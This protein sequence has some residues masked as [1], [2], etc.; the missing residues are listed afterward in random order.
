MAFRNLSRK[1]RVLYIVLGSI[2]FLLI[3]FRL[4]LPSI[5]LKYVNR[6]LAR[7]DGYTGHVK[8]IDVSLY[9]GAYTIKSIY[10]NKTGGKVPVPFFKADVIDLSVEWR[11][12]FHGR[13]VAEIEVRKPVLNFVKGPTKETS[14]TDIDNDWTV[15]VDKLIP[16]K[17][18][19]F[20]IRDG[21]IHYRD[22]YSSPKVDI[23]ATSVEIIAENLSNA[24]H[25]KDSLPSTV[26]ATASVYDG[27]A[28]MD[29][30]IDPLN[31]NLTFDL[32]AKLTTL[33]LTRLNDFLKAYGRFD[34]E[35]GTI[36]LYTEAAA[37]DKLIRGYV[38]PI[39]KDL[40]VVSWK[41]DKD[42]P[43]KLAWETLIEGVSWLLTNHNKDQVATKAEFTGRTDDPS[44]N[45]WAVIGQLLR[46]AFIQAL[47]PS[48]ENS[49]SLNTVE[50]DEKKTL[51]EKIFKKSKK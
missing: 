42:K 8:D 15:V 22:Y 46:N 11:A 37:K 34:V 44:V 28:H 50:K 1:K 19:R 9:R 29:M 41:E 21:E 32:N 13:I 43:L 47:Y 38:K 36:S 2:L 20:R 10:L 30:K 31:K 3:I 39:I 16:F 7:I 23:K 25:A 33:N 5:L 18:N 14:Q 24:K 26:K 17:L 4:M 51:L 6:Q 12:I 35:K 27:E 49:V 48:L 40:Q 45:T